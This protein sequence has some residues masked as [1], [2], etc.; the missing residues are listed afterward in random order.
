VLAEAAG[1][2]HQATSAAVGDAYA[3]IKSTAANLGRRVQAIADELAAAAT[4]YSKTDEAS[5][6]R[7]SALRFES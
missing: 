3:A 6:Q 7:L 2:P 5:G 1:P 4:Q